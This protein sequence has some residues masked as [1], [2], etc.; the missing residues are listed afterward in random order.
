MMELSVKSCK[1]SSLAQNYFFI[2]KFNPRNIA[3]ISIKYVI[4][5]DL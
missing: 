2:F 5:I 1:L 3:L 4:T